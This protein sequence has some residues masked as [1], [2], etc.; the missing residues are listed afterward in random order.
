MPRIWGY[1]LINF[2]LQSLGRGMRRYSWQLKFM[3]HRFL[4]YYSFLGKFR[5]LAADSYFCY[6]AL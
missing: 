5:R 6:S 4:S 3:Q 2:F 1:C